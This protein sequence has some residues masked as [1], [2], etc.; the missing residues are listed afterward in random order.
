[1]TKL[2]GLLLSIFEYDHDHN[3]LSQRFKERMSRKTVD[4]QTKQDVEVLAGLGY[5]QELKRE[6]R[7]AEVFGFA[8]GLLGE[9]ISLYFVQ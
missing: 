2:L 8:F 6:F 4:E 9:L 1:M 5:K 3:V 7:P